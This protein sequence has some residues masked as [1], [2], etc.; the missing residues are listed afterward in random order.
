MSN[1]S[2]SEY[3]IPVF[4][5]R[6]PHHKII[7]WDK[8]CN[9]YYNKS[10]DI[11]LCDDDVAFHNLPPHFGHFADIFMDPSNV[12]DIYG[13]LVKKND[14]KIVINVGHTADTFS[15]VFDDYVLFNAY[16]DSTKEWHIV[17]PCPMPNRSS[18]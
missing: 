15:V 2:E 11:Y 10:N 17:F 6:H 5:P 16:M 4:P 14:A 1:Q 8:T 3:L 7:Y 13:P 18:F 12:I 9:Q